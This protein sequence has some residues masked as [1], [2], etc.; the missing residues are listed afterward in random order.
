MKTCDVAGC[1]RKHHAHGYCDTHYF[2]KSK[3]GDVR[4]D[5]PIHRYNGRTG[6]R[7]VS[8]CSVAGCD[9]KQRSHGYCDTHYSRKSKHGDVMADSPIRHRSSLGYTLRKNGYVQVSKGGRLVL[10]HRLVMAQHLGRELSDHESVHHIN[11]IRDDNRIENLELWSKSQ[12]YGQRVVDKLAWC[13]EFLAQ[14]EGSHLDL[15]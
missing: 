1:D 9:R 3:H 15:L 10:A 5:I 13:R 11:G 2:R 8:I 6:A 7:T 4:A 12:P 14:Y